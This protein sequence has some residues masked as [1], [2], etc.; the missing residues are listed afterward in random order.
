MAKKKSSVL[1]GFP[2]GAWSGAC[3][4]LTSSS[5][6]IGLSTTAVPKPLIFVVLSAVLSAILLIGGVVG[7]TLFKQFSKPRKGR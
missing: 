7:F 1:K 2:S 6:V 3:F 4:G 5:I